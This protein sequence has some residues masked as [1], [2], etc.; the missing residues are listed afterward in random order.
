MH[1][2]LLSIRERMKQLVLQLNQVRKGVSLPLRK[3]SMF[4]GDVEAK[5]CVVPCYQ[6]S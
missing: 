5:N 6:L 3:L 1:S 2:V 4:P